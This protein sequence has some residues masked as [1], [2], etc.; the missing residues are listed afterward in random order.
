MARFL[1]VFCSL[2]L[3]FPT[4]AADIPLVVHVWPWRTAGDDAAKIGEGNCRAVI[5]KGERYE[6]DGK[7]TK[8]LKNRTQRTL[9]VYMPAQ[10]KDTGIAMLMCSGGGYWNLAW[11][12]EGTEIAEWL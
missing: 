11:D 9:T 8:W 7:P 6:V 12:V 3:T 10:D 5:V 4:L 2:L 1:L